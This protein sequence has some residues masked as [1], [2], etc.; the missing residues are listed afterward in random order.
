[1]REN[2]HDNNKNNNENNNNNN[3]INAMWTW[4][5]LLSCALPYI[6]EQLR[7][8]SVTPKRPPHIVAAVVVAAID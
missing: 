2:G 4:F 3:M 6:I 7:G 1:M 5:A 8:I